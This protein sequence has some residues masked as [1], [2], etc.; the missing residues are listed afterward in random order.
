MTASITPLQRR[1]TQSRE[2][3]LQCALVD[4]KFVI[5]KSRVRVAKV[6]QEPAPM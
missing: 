3:F 1:Q 5:E 4:P 2:A 6:Y